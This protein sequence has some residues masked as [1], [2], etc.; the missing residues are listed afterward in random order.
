LTAA[1]ATTTAILRANRNVLEQ[2]AAKLE[3]QSMVTG[4]ELSG[5]LSGVETWGTG[6]SGAFRSLHDN[7]SLEKESNPFDF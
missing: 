1:D 3:K 4:E 7:V 5:V 6:Q 2:L